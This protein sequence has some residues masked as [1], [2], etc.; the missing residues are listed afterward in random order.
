MNENMIYL[1]L[2][3]DNMNR[4]VFKINEN[5]VKEFINGIE[6]ATSYI[7]PFFGIPIYSVKNVENKKIILN[8]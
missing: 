4:L 1:D 7:S 2:V 8:I 5:N 6:K 3:I